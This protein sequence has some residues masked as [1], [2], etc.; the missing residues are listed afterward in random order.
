M[1]RQL[2]TGIADE[3]AYVDVA[4]RAL[5]GPLH[6]ADAS[7]AFEGIFRLASSSARDSDSSN[8]DAAV[9]RT[10]ALGVLSDI[11]RRDVSIK[12]L[13]GR[14]SNLITQLPSFVATVA[15]TDQCSAMIN[16]IETLSNVKED[17]HKAN[18]ER[19][20]PKLMAVLLPMVRNEAMSKFALLILKSLLLS[21]NR[22][23]CQNHFSSI[24]SA[25]FAI[26]DKAQSYDIAAECLAL[27]IAT[28]SVDAW[29]LNWGTACWTCARLIAALGIYTLPA[30]IG[31][32]AQGLD[33]GNSSRHG[34]EKA[35]WC[36]RWFRG[37]SAVLRK[38]SSMW[39]PI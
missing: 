36:E 37:Y 1:I 18:L 12:D 14:V 2:I 22:S 20:I 13:S 17:E 31:A 24:K 3:R 29:S 34:Y 4:S 39:I 9:V 19:A 21:N 15:S 23:M 8:L 6:S 38:V 5:S 25:C 26:L 10:A 33:I 32:A 7:A 35:L 28:E 27:V 30:S 11:L 16:I